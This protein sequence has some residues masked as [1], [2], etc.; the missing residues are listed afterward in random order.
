MID[1]LR[2]NWPDDYK[3]RPALD[4]LYEICEHSENLFAW[5][6]DIGR[7]YKPTQYDLETVAL[8]DI[9]VDAISHF[10]QVSMRVVASLP[11]SRLSEAVRRSVLEEGDDDIMDGACGEA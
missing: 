1:Y 2:D 3:E 10:R 5:Y 6:A 7:S 9:D 11:S 8:E 4:I